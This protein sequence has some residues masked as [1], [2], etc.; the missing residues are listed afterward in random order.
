MKD[1]GL[2]NLPAFKGG[3][4]VAMKLARDKLDS[5]VQ[6]YRDVLR[7]PTQQRDDGAWTVEFGSSLLWLDPSDTAQ[8]EV[9]L[10]V[11]VED[12][13]LAREYFREIPGSL[14]PE[15]EKLPKGYPGFWIQNPVGLIHLVSK[16]GA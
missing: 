6:F 13:E 1:P 4:N 8:G 12:V 2:T 9:W 7:L 5:V 15:A 10:E 14:A 16:D 3:P 11:V